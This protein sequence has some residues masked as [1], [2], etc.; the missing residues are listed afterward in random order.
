MRALLAAALLCAASNAHAEVASC[1][2]AESGRQTASS[3]RFDWRAMIAAHRTRS[4]I[5]RGL[6]SFRGRFT[7]AS[8]LRTID[9]Q[10]PC[11]VD[12]ASA[13]QPISSFLIA[14]QAISGS[15]FGNGFGVH[16]TDI[17]SGFRVKKEGQQFIER[18]V[19]LASPCDW[20]AYRPATRTRGDATP[21]TPRWSVPENLGRRSCR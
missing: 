3:E 15:R 16:T 13:G 12:P 8:R 4:R 20:T 21:P 10:P 5:M 19:T 14:F 9:C 17:C 11:P 2:G 18:D 1:Y 7:I 6:N